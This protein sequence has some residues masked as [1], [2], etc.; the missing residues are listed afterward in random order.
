MNKL[1]KRE[2]SCESV[3]QSCLTVYKTMDCSP[4]GSSVHEILQAR[5]LEWI[6]IPFSRGSSQRRDQTRVSRIA[7]RRFTLW[8][9][10]NWGAKRL[11]GSWR[12]TQ[13]L[14]RE[15]EVWAQAVW[16]LSPQRWPLFTLPLPSAQNRLCHVAQFCFL[17]RCVKKKIGGGIWAL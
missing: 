5:I 11:H 16:L 10:G 3:T 12:E 6:A 14:C 17:K 13:L 2:K 1:F 15:A 4:P 8:A 9:P 7:G